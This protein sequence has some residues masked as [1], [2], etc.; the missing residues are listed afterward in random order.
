M[1]GGANMIANRWLSACARLAALSG[2]LALAGLPA[3]AALPAMPEVAQVR[4]ALHND[5]PG[6]PETAARVRTRIVFDLPPLTARQPKAASAALLQ[7]TRS[8]DGMEW[9]LRLA[10]PLSARAENQLRALPRRIP[11]LQVSL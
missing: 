5:A 1:N 9:T 3:S 6:S 7:P 4:A 8:A 11:G 10:A 2:L